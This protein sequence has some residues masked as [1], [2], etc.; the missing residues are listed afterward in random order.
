MTDSLIPNGNGMSEGKWF[1]DVGA[2]TPL[3]DAARHVLK[4]RLEVAEKYLKSI[5]KANGS[6]CG[7]NV[8]A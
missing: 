6:P 4:T 7:V 1:N 3:A 2:D 5:A 8:F